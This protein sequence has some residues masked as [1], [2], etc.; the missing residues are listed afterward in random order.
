VYAVVT[1]GSKVNKAALREVVESIYRSEF[2][3]TKR[4]I[5]HLGEE[6]LERNEEEYLLAS[7]KLV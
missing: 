1:T 2:S 3:G 6:G 5:G 7:Y 4:V